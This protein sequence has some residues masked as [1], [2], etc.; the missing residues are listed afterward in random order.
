MVCI[1]PLFFVSTY[2]LRRVAAD[3]RALI[4]D[5]VDVAAPSRVE[6]PDSH[7]AQ[8]EASVR[9]ASDVSVGGVGPD[10]GGDESSD[11]DFV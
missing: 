8:P 11:D 9:K 3:A 1:S 7:P 6:L 4:A 2:Y 10:V 5:G